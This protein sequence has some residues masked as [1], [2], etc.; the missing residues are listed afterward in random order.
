MAT[1]KVE[2]LSEVMYDDFGTRVLITDPAS[3]KYLKQAREKK[4]ETSEK[5][6]GG[7][8][9]WDNFIERWES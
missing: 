2:V 5:F 7:R 3:E 9:G 6:C 8:S 1:K 4:E